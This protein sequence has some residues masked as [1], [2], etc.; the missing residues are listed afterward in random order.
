M[1][2]ETL[3]LPR[4]V[5]HR[6]RFTIASFLVASSA[7]SGSAL[8]R[9]GAPAASADEP[10]S[11]D[12]QIDRE[13]EE[14]WHEAGGHWDTAN[15]AEAIVLYERGLQ[16]AKRHGHWAAPHLQIALAESHL[17]QYSID[18]QPKHLR[19]SRELFRDFFV[20][21][22]ADIEDLNGRAKRGLEEAERVLA[23]LD[24]DPEPR[25]GERGKTG[26]A[27]AGPEPSS[28]EPS[29]SSPNDPD[30]KPP[31]SVDH[32]GEVRGP[33]RALAFAGLGLG[34]GALGTGA[35]LLIFAS[36]IQTIADG[37]AGDQGVFEPNQV[38]YVETLERRYLIA[39]SIVS[40]AGAAI[41][42]ASGV[43]LARI[44][45]A[46]TLSVGAGVS[47]RGFGVQVQGRF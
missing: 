44:R 45:R 35:G 32:T 15:Y 36:R 13:I 17:R 23:G 2:P 1:E 11:G 12:T 16:L 22:G 10:A 19:Q 40:V 38:R 37:Q 3:G 42:V 8:A 31:N 29:T 34:V 5:M 33:K 27:P 46:P 30:P 39:G 4:D 26:D 18:D 9:R 28:A 25:A 41:L 14:F 24:S 6:L 47:P 43:A 7:V 20:S 21:D